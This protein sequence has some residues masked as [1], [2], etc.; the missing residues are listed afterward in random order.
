[1]R[2]S[3]NKIISIVFL[4]VFFGLGW[5]SIGSDNEFYVRFRETIPKPVRQWLKQTVFIIPSLIDENKRQKTYIPKLIKEINNLKVKVLRLEK[6]SV[7]FPPKSR[8]FD[9]SRQAVP[10]PKSAKV[11]LIAGQSNSA[12][13]VRSTEYQ[14][15]P[16]VNYFN[17]SCYE[18]EN[19]V[20]GATGAGE[21]VVPGIASKLTSK[22][23]YIFL[24]MGWTATSI[25]HWTADNNGLSDYINK[26]LADLQRQ[27]HNLDAVVW[28]QGERDARL[29]IDYVSHFNEMRL[30]M[31]RGLSS[32]HKVKFVVTQTSICGGLN[33]EY[34][35]EQQL[36]LGNDENTY[37]LEV[38]DNLGM[39]YRYDSCHFNELG[40][41]AIAKAISFTL[42][43]ILK[44]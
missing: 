21:S 37:V 34:L 5:V 6:D 42:N 14:S 39:E 9:R 8:H 44:D 17:G 43:N 3:Q 32:N 27:G 15:K 4:I 40:T 36:Q 10:C 13:H 23:P 33:D 29:N 31:L 11:I 30:I 19:P 7:V 26:N 41:E 16:H 35:N 2:I 1:M 28:I 22:S 12:N 18:L 20:F 38:T 25:I 24:T